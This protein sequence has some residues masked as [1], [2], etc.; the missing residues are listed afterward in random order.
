VSIFVRTGD[1]FRGLAGWRARLAAFLAGAISALGFPPFEFF[2]GLLLGIAALVLL[3]DGASGRPRPVRSAGL[4]G[5]AFGFGQFLVGLHWIGFAFLVDA[6]AHEWQIP[7]V[8]IL[9]PGGL[10]LFTTAAMAAAMRFWKPGA[11]RLFV[12]TIAY[13]LAEWLRGHVLT[14][15]P[16]NI[17]GY[18]WGASLGV[19]QSTALIGVYGLTVLTVLV[20]ASL[21]EL[22]AE[23]P[24]WS[25]P[26][27]M[28]GIFVAL[29]AFGA[30][31]LAGAADQ[32]VPGV[33]LRIVQPNI[34]Q[35]DKYRPEL[36][37]RNWDRLIALSH[38]TAKQP[39]THIIWPEAAP[40]F[41]LTR[42]PE[43]L[44]EIAMLTGN[45]KVLLTGALR[46]QR[47]DNRMR[48]Y[49][50]FYVFGHRGR[51]LAV[52]DKFHLVPFGEYLPLESTMK[53]LGLS[54]LVGIEGSFSTGDGPHTID[55]PG[56][57]PVGPLICYEILFPDE[58]V[59]ARRPGWIV[60]VSDDSWFGPWAG[61]LQHLLIAQT[62]AIEEGLPIVRATNSGI[63]AVID[64]FGRIRTKLELD[65]M[66]TIDAPL[67][68]RIEPTFYA[69][70]GKYSFWF[71][72][73]L[74]CTAS[75]FL[76]RTDSHRLQET[77]I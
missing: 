54:K 74:C 57:P 29:F 68:A 56:G 12:F 48:Y 36:I 58:I 10:A 35:A 19:M 4:L 50:S 34:A 47:N 24:R 14:G 31:R 38:A 15:F 33:R 76:R 23:K 49:N 59:E 40:P 16:W 13:S 26:A 52:Y 9:F 7:F 43:A 77:P 42:S 44:D 6:S 72:L 61:P 18:G 25:V 67:P 27:A 71:L 30:F 32:T 20:G 62:R 11:G 75:Y 66:G 41:V 51:I 8:A 5:W 39:P 2:P 37:E 28:A 70:A 3:L 1:F 17:A 21:A 73:L 46:A 69:R 64:P 63:S 60:N 53:S 22:F 55:L 45:D 65:R